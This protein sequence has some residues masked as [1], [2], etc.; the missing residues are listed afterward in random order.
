MAVADVSVI[1]MVEVF[2]FKVRLAWLVLV[3]HAVPVLVMVQVPEPMV[4]VLVPL[5][6]ASVPTLTFLLLAS[7][8]P[9]VRVKALLVVVAISSASANCQVPPTPLKVSGL[10]I[11]FPLLVMVLVPDVAAN[12]MAVAL[13]VAMVIPEASVSEPSIVLGN[14]GPVP[15]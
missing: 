7:K 5:P 12:V 11:I 9:L 6:K 2:S 15:V 4:S 13:P 8:V 14:V 10:S 3:S 1:F